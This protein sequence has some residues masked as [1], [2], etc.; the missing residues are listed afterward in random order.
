MTDP[1]REAA[2]LWGTGGDDCEKAH[3]RSSLAIERS[4]RSLPPSRLLD[5]L[6]CPLDDDPPWDPGAQR[7]DIRMLQST[8]RARYPDCG[9]LSE[10]EAAMPCSRCLKSI[11]PW[12][13]RTVS[14]AVRR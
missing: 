13:A 3:Q 11:V 10:Q 8:L 14:H 1:E 7:G 6:G 4:T 9:R 12:S 5:S 2:W